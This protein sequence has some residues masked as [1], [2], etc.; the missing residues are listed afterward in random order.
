MTLKTHLFCKNQAFAFSGFA[1]R[2]LTYEGLDTTGLE[3]Q[4]NR[5]QEALEKDDFRAA[6]M[7]KLTG[8]AFYRAELGKKDR[9][10]IQLRRH[11]GQGV[12]LF[13]EVLR[14][15]AYDKSRFLGGA[16]I[17]ESKIPDLQISDLEKAPELGH[18]PKEARRFRLLDKVLIWD[19][20]QNAAFQAS[21]P[22][23]LIGS[24]GSGKTALVLEKLKERSGRMLYVTLS[25]FLAEN[26]R[27]LYHSSG[28]SREDQDVDFLNFREFMETL[29]VPEG[30]EV[31]DRDFLGWFNRQGR[32]AP[33]LDAHRLKE[34][35]KGVLTGF[36]VEKPWMDRE[37]YLRLGVRQ[38]IFSE[39]QRPKV[40]DLFEKYLAFL[41]EQKLF[42]PNILAHARLSQVEPVYDLVAID[43]V[44]DITNTQLSLLLRS[45]KKEGQFILCG[46]SNQ[47]VH[48]NFF[49]WSNLKSYF[50]QQ[51]NQTRDITRILQANYRNTR[52]ITELANRLLR[53]KQ[54]RFGSIDRESH[55]LV[56]CAND[57]SGEVV[58]LKDSDKVRKEIDQKTSQSAAFAVVVMREEDKAEA[59]KT[60]KTPLIFSIFE[61]KGL[62]YDNVILLNFASQERRI[63]QEIASDITTEDLDGDFQFSRSKDKGDK[64]LE[65]YKF[66]IN[67]LYVAIT[68]AVKNLYW[69]EQDPD[70][71]FLKLLGFGQDEKALQ[72]QEQKSS[73]E[74][75]EKEARRLEMQGKLEQ[76]QAINQKLLKH[77]P[78]PWTVL[79]IPNLQD[80]AS[81]GLA[82]KSVSTKQRERLFEWAL[83][84]KEPLTLSALEA[85]KYAHPL[86]AIH[87]RE[88]ILAKWTAPY[89]H[90]NPKDIWREIEAHGLSYR[91]PF[92]L[93]PLMLATRAGNVPM[94][95]Q[96][97][98]RGSDPELLDTRGWSAY[99]HALD[100]AFRLPEF[101]Q[102]HF[103]ALQDRL[104]PESLSLEAGGRLLKLDRRQMECFL[105]HAFLVL[106]PW[107]LPL[108]ANER[109]WPGLT[110]PELAEHLE[111]LP[112]EAIPEYRKKR[113]YISGFLSK[114]ERE[115]GKHRPLFWRTE[116]GRYVL[117]PE[118]KSRLHPEAGGT[119]TN[120]NDLLFPAPLRPFASASIREF[121]EDPEH[122]ELP[123]TK[124]MKAERD[125]LEAEKEQNMA[126][127]KELEAM[128]T[129]WQAE[130]AEQ[131]AA[132]KAEREAF[133]AE[134]QAK[135]EAREKKAAAKKEA[136]QKMKSLFE[137]FN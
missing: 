117:N 79:N 69:L 104:A 43:E 61:A 3:T 9:L 116:R 93:T 33:E 108:H 96:L 16:S 40:Y 87:Q 35:F 123:H 109:H 71:G 37:S 27:R 52:P 66:F 22:C 107:T 24:A 29:E 101:A 11:Q 39:S 50:Y 130:L 49:S 97:L 56:D 78:V 48:P 70:H 86:Q 18:L 113:T 127:I 51:D 84:S 88:R 73:H 124:Q 26:A 134:R 89:K 5:V 19:D 118:L 65:T 44:Q 30:R 25:P 46:D 111:K 82:P 122:F 102:K 131:E 125:R 59:A 72:L 133:K 85:H 76:A 17:D 54:K 20:A 4:I 112:F 99:H 120:I 31:Q 38:S 128:R 75:W 129:K 137:E 98:D 55:Y 95:E 110:A 7:K 10:L 80:A 12:A 36:S 132:R 15:H 6:Q 74:E 105:V 121:L 53:L 64:S 106:Q 119:F 28:F 77:R 45:L 57:L 34:E 47:I 2:V 94:V 83:L 90:P 91:N 42:E 103:P 32:Q 58:H 23:L 68:R 8:G 92:N 135:K 60:F 100:E 81:K 67:S 63:F 115:M 136:E 62:E 13:L 21:L 114:F 126:R 14:N 41:K 1:M